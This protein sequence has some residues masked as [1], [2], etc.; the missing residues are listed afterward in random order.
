MLALGAAPGVGGAQSL[1][2]PPSSAA[3]NWAGFHR[4]ANLSGYAA[5][6]SLTSSNVGSLGVR[7]ATATFGQALDS[8]VVTKTQLGMLTFV[9]TESG[10]ELAFTVGSGSPVW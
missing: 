5:N 2:G 1:A 8:A 6:S 10:D 3:Y 9:G 4:D 7:W